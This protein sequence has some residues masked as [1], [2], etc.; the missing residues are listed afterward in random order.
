MGS[1]DNYIAGV[2]NPIFL[3]KHYNW[4]ICCNLVIFKY[5]E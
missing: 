4:D 5:L 2:G 3:N 1:L